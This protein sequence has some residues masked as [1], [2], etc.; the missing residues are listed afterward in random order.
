[1]NWSVGINDPFRSSAHTARAS[2][3]IL[4]DQRAGRNEPIVMVVH[5]AAAPRITYTDR[6]K[7]ALA[8]S[9]EITEESRPRRGADR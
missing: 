6:G 3:G 9:G 2:T 4:Q 1:M 5:L 7:S 8:L